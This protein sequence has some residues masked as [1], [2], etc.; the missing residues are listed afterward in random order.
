MAKKRRRR[1]RHRA[2][3][4]GDGQVRTATATRTSGP[5]RS[6]A[7]KKDLARQRRE[8]LLQRQQRSRHIRRLMLATG[9]GAVAALLLFQATKPKE[10]TTPTSSP[11]PSASGQLPGMLT[12]DAPWP[13]NAAEAQARSDADGLPPA[14][15]ALQVDANLRIFVRGEPVA[16]PKDIG[17]DGTTNTSLQTRDSTGTMHVGSQTPFD[18]TLGEFFD[19]WGVRLTDTCVGGYCASSNE[20][21]QAFVD[22]N[23][24]PGNPRDV[25]LNDKAVIVL[26]FGT[27]DQ[28]PSPIPSTFDFTST[29]P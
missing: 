27:P 23:E 19:V 20:T 9:V 25:P 15:D 14:G 18:F 22:G 2:H 26:T 29:T 17:I 21:L 8:E 10:Q 5:S 7:E 4:Q 3:V 13:A 28:L 6:R 16:V 24:V 12:S 1:D 11:S